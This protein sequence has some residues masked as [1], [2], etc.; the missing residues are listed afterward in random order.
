MSFAGLKDPKERA[1]VILY[2]NDKTKNP[3]PLN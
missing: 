2:M 3:L 1:A